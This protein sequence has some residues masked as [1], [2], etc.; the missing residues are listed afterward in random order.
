[1]PRLLRCILFLSASLEQVQPR[2]IN[3]T[4]GMAARPQI[5]AVSLR[6]SDWRSGP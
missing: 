6:C 4:A 5:G 2:R 3:D 1:L